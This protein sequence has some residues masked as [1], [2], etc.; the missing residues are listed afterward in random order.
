MGVETPQLALRMC[1]YNRN[2][3]RGLAI[4]PAAHDMPVLK[5]RSEFH[6]VECLD[7][8]VFGAHR[9]GVRLKQRR[10]S[11]PTRA[12]SAVR[13]VGSN[14]SV[15]CVYIMRAIPAAGRPGSGG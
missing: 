10:R 3:A 6:M 8:E 5:T 12:P 1:Q 14:N 13:L 11:R 4:F 7:P 9:C 2:L 15:A